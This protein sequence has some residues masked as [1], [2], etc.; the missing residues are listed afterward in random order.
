MDPAQPTTQTEPTTEQIVQSIYNFAA[1]QMRAGV[2]PADIEKQL[3][4]Q[5]LDAEGAATVVAN[6]ANARK[7]ALK[8][9]GQ[10][11]ML[12]GALWCIGGTVVTVLT[13]QA[14]VN[15]GGGRYVVAWGAIVFGAIEFFRG[16]F[17]STSGT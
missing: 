17:Q 4:N 10:K 14:A 13:H 7:Q 8:K 1:Q 9:A 12:Y 6:L 2:A 11:K 5:G 16:L 15:S 3:V